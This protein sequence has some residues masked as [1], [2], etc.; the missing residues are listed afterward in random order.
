MSAPDVTYVRWPD[1]AEVRADLRARLRP[2]LLLVAPDAAPPDVV[3]DLEDWV[4]VPADERDISVRANRLAR[5][6]RGA[7]ETSSDALAGSS[8]GPPPEPGEW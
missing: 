3:D 8:G 1:E 5:L 2:R 7:A 4:R 6:A